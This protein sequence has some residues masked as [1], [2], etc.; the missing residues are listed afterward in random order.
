MK[1]NIARRCLHKFQKKITPRIKH[2]PYKE[3]TMAKK[4]KAK[5]GKRGG[6]LTKMTYDLS[7]ELQAVVKAKKLTRPQIMKK[8]WAYI[9]SHRCQDTK[10]RRL[11]VPDAKL[12][13]VFG[14]KRPIDMLKLAGVLNKHIG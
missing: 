6:G 8:I 10:N 5:S 9:K 3:L 12:T 1:S 13:A 2:T 14:S 11:I 4:K 7:S